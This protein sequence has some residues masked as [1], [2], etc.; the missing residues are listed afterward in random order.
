MKVEKKRYR[1][2][3]AFIVDS[4]AFLAHMEVMGQPQEEKVKEVADDVTKMKKSAAK[5]MKTWKKP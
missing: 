3:Q 5:L 4:L 2:M 1:A